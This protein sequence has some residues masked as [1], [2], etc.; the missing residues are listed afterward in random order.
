VNLQHYTIKS[1][2]GGCYLTDWVIEGSNDEGRTWTA[3]DTRHTDTLIGKY[4]VET[5]R[6]SSSDSSISFRLIRL[7]MTDKRKTKP[8]ATRC[9]HQAKLC[10]IEFFG[11]LVSPPQ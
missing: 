9:C 6:C 8:G 10:N 2:G 5:F 3:I 1:S 11:F 7:R 4:L